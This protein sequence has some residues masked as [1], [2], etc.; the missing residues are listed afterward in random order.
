MT[1]SAFELMETTIYKETLEETARKQNSSEGLTNICDAAYEFYVMVERAIRGILTVKNLTEQNKKL[2]KYAFGQLLS[3]EDLFQVFLRKCKIDSS[4]SELEAEEHDY[5][6]Y[7]KL[8]RLFC[9][10]L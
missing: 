5:F 2:Y 9:L 10:Y 7:E 1:V 6:L 4:E 3:N 8:T